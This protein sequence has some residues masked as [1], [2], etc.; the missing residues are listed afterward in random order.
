MIRH[1]KSTSASR[2]ANFTQPRE[3]KITRVFILIA[4]FIAALWAA[5][6]LSIRLAQ[7]KQLL[8]LSNDLTRVKSQNSGLRK[9]VLNLKDSPEYIEWLARKDLGLIKPDEDAY[10]VINARKGHR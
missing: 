9:D 6:P 8:S 3:S 1:S 7:Q 10:V 2:I 5:S 4:F